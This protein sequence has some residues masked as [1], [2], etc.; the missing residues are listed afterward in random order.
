MTEFSEYDKSVIDRAVRSI[1]EDFRFVSSIPT[2]Q[3]VYWLRFD[4]NVGKKREVRREIQR[5]M[6]EDF[7][8]K[9]MWEDSR[10]V[11]INIKN[12]VN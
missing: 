2:N 12:K 3:E 11:C 5:Q 9:I 1:E 8:V 6:R 4:S 7:G 10:T